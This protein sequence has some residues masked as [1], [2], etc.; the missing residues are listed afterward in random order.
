MRILVLGGE[1]MLGHKVFQTLSPR[2]ETWATVRGPAGAARQLPVYAMADERSVIGGVDAH[3]IDGVVRAFERAKP[4]VVVNCVG[5]VKQRAEAHDPLV[6]VTVN[7][8]FPHRLAGLCGATG[9]R[10]IQV[11]TDCVFS[12]RRGRYAETDV[13][14]AD[15]LYGRSKLLGEVMGP[16]CLTVRTSIVGREFRRRTGLLE[17]F[18]NQRGLTVHGY[19]RMMFS[20]FPTRSFAG[21]LA[22]VIERHSG[23]E[24]LYHVAS[25]P[26]SKY[27]LLVKL[28]DALKLDI[29]IE[30][31][32]GP[33]IDRTLDGSRFVND[34]GYS[35]PTWDQLI[36]DIAADQTP[37]E[38]W[39]AQ[40]ATA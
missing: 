20:G 36:A 28:R 6:S 29:A 18:L 31:I 19:R 26:I 7:S 27:D 40:H 22:A 21:I 38:E 32:D 15:D 39:R 34:T 10:L 2:F 24:G 35:I 12:G 1:G 30:A 3:D 14:D 4:D 37:Y 33:C 16:G 13:A 25:A 17:W 8:L 9:A 23:L 5:I 11:S